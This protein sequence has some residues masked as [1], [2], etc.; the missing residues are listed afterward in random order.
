VGPCRP[1]VACRDIGI[2]FQQIQKYEKGR[3]R[4]SASRLRQIAHILQVTEAWFFEGAEDLAVAEFLA[5]RD[6]LRLTKAF[7]Q[8]SQPRRANVLKLIET[9]ADQKA[10]A[11]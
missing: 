5:T 10:A 2:S 8:L 3:N 4:I 7:L 9:I 11:E 6:G 1:P